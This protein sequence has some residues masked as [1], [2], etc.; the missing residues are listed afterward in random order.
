MSADRRKCNLPENEP[1]KQEKQ[2]QRQRNLR[3]QRACPSTS[4]SS[5]CYLS[6]RLL[7]HLP[8]DNHTVSGGTGDTLSDHIRTTAR[9][10]MTSEANVMTAPSTASDMLDNRAQTVNGRRSRDRGGRK[11]RRRNGGRKRNERRGR[12]KRNERRRKKERGT[13]GE[14]EG[15]GTEEED[16]EEDEDG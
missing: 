16:K 10:L 1:E 12:R 3:L 4:S 2:Q 9:K 13:N 11:K 5:A 15:R 7:S 8:L 14:E 6:P